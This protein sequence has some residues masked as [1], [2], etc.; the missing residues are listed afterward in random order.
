MFKKVILAVA[1]FPALAF[2]SVMHSAVIDNAPVVKSFTCQKYTD[3]EMNM[4]Q[5]F[6][7]DNPVTNLV[8]DIEQTKYQFIVKKNDLFKDDIRLDIP[9]GG[10]ISG[11]SGNAQD[12]MFRRIDGNGK[13][14][15]IIYMA[16]R[17]KHS[18]G[19]IN[20]AVYIADCTRN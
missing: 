13:P 10:N 9:E 4:V 12:M 19:E 20:R 14:F 7:T 3:N 6:L 17:S 11:V 5:G 18:D 15:F 1:L 16:N 8:F 2:G